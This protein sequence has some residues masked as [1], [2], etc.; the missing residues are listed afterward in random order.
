MAQREKDQRTGQV[1]PAG[2]PVIL[3]R[4]GVTQDASFSWKNT[5][6]IAGSIV[7]II[8][9]SAS[10]WMRMRPGSP[11]PSGIAVPTASAPAPAV[12]TLP[13]PAASTPPESTASAPQM[14]QLTSQATEPRV[15]TAQSRRAARPVAASAGGESAA[16]V[17]TVPPAP[18]SVREPVQSGRLRIA[19]EQSLEGDAA[20]IFAAGV[21]AH[22]VGDFA[23]ARSSYERVLALQPND[24]DALNNLGIVLAALRDFDQAESMLRR[25]V[26]IAPR[27]AVAWN[28]L[29]T[30]LAQRAQPADAVAAFQ[31]A[32]A[33]DP[34]HQGARV[35]MAQQF[36]AIGAA[37]RARQ[38]LEEVIAMNPAMPE[39]HYALGQA[40][41][42]EQKW[43]DAIRSYESFVRVA[44]PRMSADV[45]RVQQR[46]QL[47]SVRAR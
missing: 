12:A 32:L 25:A 39:A 21:A 24:V 18:V 35:S 13:R 26:R 6:T 40:L 34:E 20:R 1:P 29:G 44:P 15:P 8:G 36:L 38:A 22:R 9:A 17:V 5:L 2:T 41:E 16:R 31:Q 33:L 30:V 37:D 42:M 43:K 7:V 3:R 46:I 45:D 4:R 23:A 10:L 28:N 27:N 11:A 47:L 14:E 19:V